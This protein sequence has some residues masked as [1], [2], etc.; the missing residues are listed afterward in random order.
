MNQKKNVP[1]GIDG[2]LLNTSDSMSISHLISHAIL[3][4]WWLEQ[5]SLEDVHC[6]LT[7]EYYSVLRSTTPYCKVLPSTTE[8]YSMLQSIAQYYTVLLRTT[9][10]FTVLH[11]KIP[12][13]KV[14]QR[15]TPDYK[16]VHS[17]AT[18]PNRAPATENVQMQP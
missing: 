11:S 2:D 6:C 4:C 7:T 18:S 13:Y 12:Y 1:I 17:S 3:F 8:Y 16:L 15:K 10:Y 9:K 14:L 5:G